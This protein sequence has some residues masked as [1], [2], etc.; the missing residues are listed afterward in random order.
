MFKMNQI[1]FTFHKFSKILN[2]SQTGWIIISIIQDVDI[3]VIEPTVFSSLT[4]VRPLGVSIFSFINDSDDQPPIRNN[5]TCL[6]SIKMNE[7]KEAIAFLLYQDLDIL[8]LFV[9]SRYSPLISF[10]QIDYLIM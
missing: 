2:H 5:A 4:L 1:I 8:G 7:N 6:L 9:P 10:W 3:P